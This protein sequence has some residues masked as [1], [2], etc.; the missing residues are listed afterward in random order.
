MVYANTNYHVTLIFC[1]NYS[2]YMY[3]FCDQEL[4]YCDASVYISL[5]PVC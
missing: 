3:V 2:K 4:S 1:D 5:S